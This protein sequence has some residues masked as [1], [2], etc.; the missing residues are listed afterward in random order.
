MPIRTYTPRQRNSKHQASAKTR[1]RPA[2]CGAFQSRCQLQRRQALR[3][4]PPPTIGRVDL[5]R[6]PDRAAPGSSNGLQRKLTFGR[7]PGPALSGSATPQDTSPALWQT[8]ATATV[9]HAVCNGMKNV[10]R[11]LDLGSSVAEFDLALEGYF[12]ENQAFHDL[13]KGKADIVAGDKGTGKTA[14][15]RILQKRY[16]AIPDLAGVEVLSAFN[17][18]GNPIFQRLVQQPSLSEGQYT[19]VWKSYVFSLVGNWLIEIFDPKQSENL[20][21][22]AQMLE[23]TGLRSKDD[24]PETV[25]GRI[26][27]AISRLWH[28]KSASLEFTFSETGLPMIVPKVEFESSASSER[29]R[30]EIRHETSLRLLDK[31]LKEVGYSVWIV[32]DRLDEAFQGFP[33]VEIPALRALFRTYLDLLEFKNFRL[34]LFVRRDLFRKIVGTTFVNLTHINARRTEIVWEEADLLNLLCQRVRKSKQLLEHL[35]AERSTDEELFY[36]LFPDKV[37][38]AERKPT[39]WNWMMARIRDGNNVK[40][41]RNLIDLAHMAQQSQTRAEARAPRAFA[42]DMPLIEADSVRAAQSRLS[43][44]RVEDTLLAEAGDLAALIDRFRSSK[45]EHNETTLRDTLRLPDAEMW[46]AIRQLV[47]IGFLEEFK[48]SWKIPMLYRDGLD[49]TQGKAF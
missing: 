48:A 16:R 46:P 34:K 31:C 11:M 6:P 5:P 49:I 7:S 36:R 47:E 35:G 4:R 27:N 14:I 44:T 9:R 10:L 20:T 37:D 42:G 28:P 23:A 21:S 40:P 12:V 24:Q 41:P 13:V 26:M 19:S 17:P 39:T 18:T 45:A 38:A 8:C 25:F 43:A 33:H 30:S 1:L 2:Q 32:L 15:Y 22:L 29:T 3:R